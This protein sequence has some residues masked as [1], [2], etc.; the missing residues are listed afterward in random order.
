MYLWEGH[1][2]FSG[3]RL[4]PSFWQEVFPCGVY[5]YVSSFPSQG[6]KI[7][8]WA[9]RASASFSSPEAR[10]PFGQHQKS[11]PLGWSNTG[12]LRFTT[13]CQIWQ[14]WLAE[15]TKRILCACS[16]N[17]V[18]PK[19]AILGADQKERGLWGWEC[20]CVGLD[21]Y[22]AYHSRPQ[23]LR[24]FW[25]RGRLVNDILRWVALGRECERAGYLVFFI[26]STLSTSHVF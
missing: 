2:K 15:N 18:W 6:G 8:R 12:S 25:S 17:R 5:P 22:W 24:F 16:E 21:K 19:V 7:T 23:S 4:S 9:R 20:I 14:S 26:T 11:R 3:K 1:L 10:A 13:S